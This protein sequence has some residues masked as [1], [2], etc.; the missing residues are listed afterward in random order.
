M[1]SD[2]TLFFVERPGGLFLSLLLVPALVFLFLRFRRISATL[3]DFG[4]ASKKKMGAVSNA[5]FLRTFFRSL[6]FLSAVAA[7]SGVFWGIRRVPVQKSGACVSFVFDISYSMNA[8]DEGGISRL[9]ASK[10]F[11][12]ALLSRIRGSSVS[13]VIAKGDGFLAVPL[14]ED[15]E[16][17]NSLI[18]SLS[19]AL[20]TA[21]GSSIGRGVERAVSSFP[22]N[23]AQSRMVFVF[24][25]GDETDGSLSSSLASAAKYQIPV[26]LVGFGSL[27]GAEVLS[28]DGKT[29]VRTFLREERMREFARVA[30]R[31][32]SRIVPGA[33]PISYVR[34]AAKSSASFLV[35]QV[36][37]S[38]ES[39]VYESRPV[40]RH[41]L[42]IF[43]SVLFLALS[44]VFGEVNLGN[45]RK[46]FRRI[47]ISAIVLASVSCSSERMRILEGSLSFR[48]GNFREATAD[49]LGVESF[50]GDS[51]SVEYASFA[52]SSTY[53]SLGQYDSALEKLSSIVPRKVGDGYE[54]PKFAGAVFYNMGVS[55]V[56]KGEFEIAAESFKKSILADSENLDA[57]INLELCLERAANMKRGAGEKRMRG[58]AE[59]S[60]GDPKTAALFDLVR[61]SEQ[62]Q[63]IRGAPKTEESDGIDY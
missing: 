36:E 30:N 51:R 4:S 6:S 50:S 39:F 15:F 47:S 16:S 12:R 59:E 41:R 9:E 35:S 34:A 7:L 17:V 55:H 40:S 46:F 48:N 45:V 20:M 13:A 25:D 21:S 57:K 24:T 38:A 1:N 5:F 43:A 56:R 60:G 42:F 8:P 23:S 18:D 2:F 33:S 62:K 52:L 3:K 32:A 14:T 28:G 10:I 11:A 27:D 37:R 26:T 63:W 22:K 49:F 61:Q 53:I 54:N 19:P 44:Y 31:G 58:V 29:E